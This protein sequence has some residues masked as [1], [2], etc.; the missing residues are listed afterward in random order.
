MSSRPCG[1]GCR[2]ATMDDPIDDIRWRDELLQVLYWLRGERLGDGATAQ[3]LVMILVSDLALVQQHLHR[4]A[5]DGY[6]AAVEHEPLR[7]QL[8]ERGVKEGGRRFADEFAGLTGQAHGECNN[9]D[10]SCQTLGPAACASRT[11]VHAH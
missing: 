1:G 2:T 5:A 8:T 3:E 10:C 6:V 9:P 4:L 7:Y 11:A